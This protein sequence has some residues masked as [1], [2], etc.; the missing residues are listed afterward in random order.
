[1]GFQDMTPERL[2]EVAAL[3][4]SRRKGHQW[5]SEEARLAGKKG[6]ATLWGRRRLAAARLLAQEERVRAR[7]AAQ[8]ARDVAGEAARQAAREAA[9]TARVVASEAARSKA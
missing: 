3:G 4:G 7:D 1:M 9:M 6:S 5:T 8:A 2:R